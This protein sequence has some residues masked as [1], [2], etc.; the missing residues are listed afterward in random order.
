[1]KEILLGREIQQ[2]SQKSNECG[3]QLKDL[4]RHKRGF[5]S[6][7]EVIKLKLSKI[8]PNQI[9]WEA[10]KK[11]QLVFVHRIVNKTNIK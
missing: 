7:L 2:I 11:T 8:D 6:Q 5:A 4:E 1:M 10:P 9:L 3:Q